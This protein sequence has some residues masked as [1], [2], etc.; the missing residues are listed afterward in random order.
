MIRQKGDFVFDRLRN[1]VYTKAFPVNFLQNGI[2]LQR[3]LAKGFQRYSFATNRRQS[4]EIGRGTPV[5]FHHE[6]HQ[7]GI[8]FSPDVRKYFDE[9]S[10]PTV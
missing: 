7:V 8:F 5:A 1:G 2:A 9:V 4:I 10:L 3:V 6:F